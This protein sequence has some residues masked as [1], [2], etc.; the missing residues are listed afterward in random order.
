MAATVILWGIR[1]AKGAWEAYKLSPSA[2]NAAI[3]AG[4]ASGRGRTAWYSNRGAVNA[5][6]KKNPQATKPAAKATKPAASSKATQ[7]WH[8]KAGEFKAL[9]ESAI[10]NLTTSQAKLYREAVKTARGVE[11]AKTVQKLKSSA[12]ATV[13]PVGRAARRLGVGLAH[14]S[15]TGSRAGGAG[16]AAYRVGEGYLGA[17]AAIGGAEYLFSDKDKDGEEKKNGKGG[18]GKGGSKGGSKGGAKGGSTTTTTAR[19]ASLKDKYEIAQNK[20]GK[21]SERAGKAWGKKHG[22]DIS[23][24]Y[25]SMSADEMQEGLD[26]GTVSKKLY[27]KEGKLTQAER[28]EINERRDMRRGGSISADSY[29]LRKKSSKA[30]SGRVSKQT[31]WNY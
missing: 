5:A 1:L 19:P 30:K 8:N 10:Q 4:K 9:D 13:N 29:K 21:Y 2:A 17:K 16:R 14:V 18:N 11:K 7:P 3:K 31:S 12:E 15:K 20:H 27:G 23:Y 22:I 26:K 6:A 24:D 25:P 28:D